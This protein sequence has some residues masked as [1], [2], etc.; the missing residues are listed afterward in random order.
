MDIKGWA[1]TPSMDLVRHVI[2]NGAFRASIRKRGLTGPGGIKLLAQHDSSRPLGVIIKLEERPQGLWIEANVNEDISYG[3]DLAIAIRSAGGLNFSVG[4]RVED[5]DIDLDSYEREYLLI[6]RGTL[7]EVSV[8]TFPCNESAQMT[9]SDPG[10]DPYLLLRVKLAE[11][12]H[13]LKG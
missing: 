9:A 5:A 7:T 10:G 8:V 1:T 11:L 6:K 3:K 13:I 4:F 2:A 12:N